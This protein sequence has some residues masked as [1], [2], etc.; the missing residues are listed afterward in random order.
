[1]AKPGLARA[2]QARQQPNIGGRQSTSPPAAGSHRVIVEPS[3]EMEPKSNT[4][5]TTNPTSKDCKSEIVTMDRM[6]PSVRW[7]LQI[8]VTDRTQY[9]LNFLSNSLGIL[10]E[11]WKWIAPMLKP[12]DRN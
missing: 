3:K 5:S 8:K 11:N 4:C 9:P 12:Y 6:D 10:T 7:A 2:T 1:M